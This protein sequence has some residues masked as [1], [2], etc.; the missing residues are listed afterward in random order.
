[1][2]TLDAAAFR[3]PIRKAMQP[4]TIFPAYFEKF[5]GIQVGCFFSQEGFQ[6]PL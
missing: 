1:V 2:T 4:V 6:A 3:S 5:A